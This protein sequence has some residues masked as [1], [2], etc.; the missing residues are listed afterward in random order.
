MIQSGRGS[1]FAPEQRET[2]GRC[3]DF[4]ARKLERDSPVEHR[5]LGDV[6]ISHTAATEPRQD[7]I[8]TELFANHSQCELNLY[9]RQ[10]EL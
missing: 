9:E 8:V 4:G 7:E 5:I 2:I 1:G 3:G 6:H 10:R